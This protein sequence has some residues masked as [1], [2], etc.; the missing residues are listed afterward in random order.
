MTGKPR[1]PAGWIA[2]LERSEAQPAAGLTVSSDEVQ[3]GLRD[4]IARL[5][6]K[7][8]QP[9]S[10]GGTIAFLWPR[11]MPGCAARA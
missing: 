3:Q 8:K 1:A 11:S 6:S 4:A 5:E 2:A 9:S 10:D 7:Q